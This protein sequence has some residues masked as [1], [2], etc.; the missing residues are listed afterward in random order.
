MS[1]TFPAV[2][3][4]FILSHPLAVPATAFA[5]T[6]PAPPPADQLARPGKPGW[7]VSEPSGCWVW[8]GEPKKG[9]TVEWRGD[10]K[11]N[12]AEGAGELKWTYVDNGEIATEQFSGQL[13]RGKLHGHG[14]HTSANGEVYQG[15]FRD[16]LRNGHGLQVFGDLSYEG[17]FRNGDWNG[18]GVL[19]L[20]NGS[21]YEG[22]FR[23]GEFWG[24]G[25]Y[26]WANGR[27]YEGEWRNDQPNG[28]GRYLD[29]KAVWHH[30]NWRDGCFEDDNY[31]IAI[32]RLVAE[33]R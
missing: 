13:R 17:E 20:D 27:R 10:C 3:A 30:G 25:V 15:E 32:G 16:D 26:V 28:F 2:A 5:D 22:E 18:R 19:Q 4:V 24:H 29:T 7:T 21:R 12:I 1:W 23:D 11:D 33:C 31:R 8:N 9:E 14:K 6:R